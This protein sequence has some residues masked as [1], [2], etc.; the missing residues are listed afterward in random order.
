MKEYYDALNV[1]TL[2]GEYGFSWS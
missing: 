2:K 1:M